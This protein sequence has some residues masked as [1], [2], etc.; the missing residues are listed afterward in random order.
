MISELT[1]SNE[2]AFTLEQ[3]RQIDAAV[4]EVRKHAA[5]LTAK[6]M[7]S[8]ISRPT[9]T[10]SNA[11]IWAASLAERSLKALSWPKAK[12][13][14]VKTT[15]VRSLATVELAFLLSCSYSTDIKK[16]GSLLMIRR[17]NAPPM[18]I[19]LVNWIVGTYA[20]VLELLGDLDASKLNAFHRHKLLL[21]SVVMT[22]KLVSQLVK[23]LSS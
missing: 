10:K 5:R 9:T 21:R 16:G 19:V 8:A 15:F 13:A 14:V 4:G 11:I 18:A 23:G 17:K 7:A 2:L 6:D 22:S 3:H 12:E 20:K 1:Q